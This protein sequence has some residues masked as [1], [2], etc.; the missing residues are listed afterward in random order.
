MIFESVPMSTSVELVEPSFAQAI[1]AIENADSLPEQSKRHWTCSLRQIAKALERPLELIPARWTSVCLQVSQLH[2]ARVGVERKTLANHRANA[3]AALVWFCKDQGVPARGTRLTPGWSWLRNRLTERR[4]RSV[5]SGL[6]RYCS[7]QKIQPQSVTETVLD[8]YMAYRRQATALAADVGAR[9]SIARCWNQSITAIDGWP[10]RRLI[11]PAPKPAEGPPWEDFPERLRAEIQD[12]LHGLTRI[13]RSAKGKRIRPC[14]A[15]TI[16]TRRA[17]ILA[18]IRTAVRI[19]IPLQQLSSLSALVDPDVVE[20][21]IDAY[22]KRDGEEP[23]IFTI[24]LG[25]LLLSIARET[26]CADVRSLERLEDFRA[27]LE[28]YRRGGLT[29][30][31]LALI[32]QVLS[33]GVWGSVVRLPELLIRRARDQ[34]EHAPIKA[35]VTAQLAIAIAILTVAPIRLGNLATIELG[36]NLIKPGGLD[37]AYWLVFPHYD[38]KNRVTLEYPL[39]QALT[40]LI[41]EYV[42]EFRP[43][44]ARGSNACWLF[45]GETGGYK[46]PTTLSDQ[47]TKRIEKATGLRITVHQFRHAAGALILKHHPGNYELVR[48]LLGHRN[49]QT[50]IN[51]YCGLENTQAS[52]MFAKI[53]REQMTFTPE[54]IAS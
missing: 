42:H 2:H 13:R 9:R 18:A 37:S 45:P 35:A 15:S 34:Q 14:K 29:D 47:L 40:D 49:V 28:T 39:D 32:R 54:E 25:T 53:V 19:G 1:A 44:L 23:S 27:R 12:Y 21:I 51:F 3:R 48:R 17:T 20:Q 4:P 5:L 50:T 7:A 10:T 8:A 31:N 6:M 26:A 22:W 46:T 38:V 33:D 30:K 52:E 11:E 41:S 24:E 43:S 36:Q 16:R